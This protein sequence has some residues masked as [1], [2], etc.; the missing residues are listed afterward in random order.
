MNVVKEGTLRGAFTGFRGSGTKFEFLDGTRWR[1]S[2][3]TVCAAKAEDAGAR[4]FLKRGKYYLRVNHLKQAVE[5][6]PDV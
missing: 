5:V 3:A 1:Q 4:I 2:D 6:V